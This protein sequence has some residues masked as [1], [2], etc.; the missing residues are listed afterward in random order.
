MEQERELYPRRHPR[1]EDTGPQVWNWAQNY[2]V[3]ARAAV[4]RPENEAQLQ[5]IIAN[6]SGKIKVM[7]SRMSPG[8]LLLIRGTQD[9]L[10]DPAA[11]S[12]LLAATVDT[13][14]FAAATPLHEVYRT[15]TDMDRMLPCSPGVIALQTLAGAIATGTHGQGLQQS[16]LADEVQRIRLIRG[17]GEIIEFTPADPRFGAVQLALGALGVVTEITLRTR[18]A[19]LYTCEKSA[20]DAAHLHASLY[21]W[22]E[23]FPFSKAWWFPAEDQVHVWCARDATADEQ[24]HYRR[25]QEQ[26]VIRPT[27][28]STLNATVDETLRHM[29]NDTKIKEKEGKP[30]QTVTRFKDFSD[31][32]GDINQLFCRG[33]ATP[34]IN[35]EIG[36]P[37]QRAGRVINKIK[38]WHTDTNP[39]MHYPII[40]RC[41]GPSAAWLS[42]AYGENTCFFGFVVYYAED[43]SLSPDGAKFINEAEK[44]LAQEG[45][46]PHWGKYYD[47]ARY[48]WRELYPRWEH[49]RQVRSA[50]DPEG[51]FANAFIADIFNNH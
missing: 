17:D 13:A 30:Y 2:P 12:G 8:E 28:D 46:R 42:P 15:L 40:L 32:T 36:I 23:Q 4:Q 7:G 33:I 19:R 41:T 21:D 16:S 48:H 43:G 24:A 45:G 10:I 22:N 31:V 6:C 27:R 14:T 34:Q 20:C 26:P 44:L 11:L 39:H 9:V 35:I 50:L 37:L 49:F 38:Q 3:G 5:K 29:Q 51:K 1:L 18:P 47:K 25:N